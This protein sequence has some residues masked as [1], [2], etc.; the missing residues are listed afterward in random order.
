MKP[1]VLRLIALFAFAVFTF[2]LTA[3]VDN[4]DYDTGGGGG[5]SCSR[6]NLYQ[7]GPVTVMS[8]RLAQSGEWGNQNCRVESYY[9][10][11]YC[12]TDGS[13]CCVD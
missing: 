7:S 1:V 13:E 5:A 4:K 2:G 10:G 3:Q 12:F 6:C 11:T 8:C 9:E